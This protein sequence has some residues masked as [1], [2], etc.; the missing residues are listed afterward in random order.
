M[1]ILNIS[2]PINA[3]KTTVS[4]ILATRVK[5]ALFIE[6]DELLSDEE[7]E[8]L[9][10]DFKGGINLRLERLDQWLDKE[11]ENHDFD[12]ILFSYPLTKSNYNRWQQ[13]INGRVVFK[14]VTLSP[15]LDTCLTNRGTR[16]LNDWEINRIKEMYKRG[17]HQ[18]DNANLIIDNSR[19][20]PEETV[21]QIIN[22]FSLK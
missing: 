8:M 3:G 7:Q 19:Q 12:V 15:D 2:G 17:Y 20:R 13:I 18:P 5:K 21:T 6:V 22:Y 11:I 4:R 10:L 14:T 1:I 16:A 9:G